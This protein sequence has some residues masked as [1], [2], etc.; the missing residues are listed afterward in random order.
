MKKALY[1]KIA[2]SIIGCLFMVLGGLVNQGWA[3]PYYP[4]GS[5]IA[6]W[7]LTHVTDNSGVA[8]GVTAADGTVGDVSTINIYNYL[9]SDGSMGFNVDFEQGTTSYNGGATIGSTSTQNLSAYD[10]FAINIFNDNESPWYY[11]LYVASYDA[12]HHLHYFMGVGPTE[13]TSTQ[14]NGNVY[15]NNQSEQIL[16]LDLTVARDTKQVDLTNA[17]IGFAI[18][19]VLPAPNGTG[20]DYVSET[21]VA[22]VP[23]PATI[24]LFGTGLIGLAGVARKK[25]KKV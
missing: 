5:D 1:N 16:S 15:L 4:S 10:S 20:R 23:E 2:M 8:G 13:L 21:R 11:A 24:L 14:N 17:Y 3:L 9:A 7:T 22:P 19:N 12:S 25:V 18:G 6:S